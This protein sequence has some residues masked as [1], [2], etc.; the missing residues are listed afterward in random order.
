M[1]GEATPSQLAA[2]LMGLRMR[3]ETV[4]ELAGFA[5][6]MR[7][8]VVRVE[9]PDGHHRR[10]RDR[11]RRQRHVQHLDRGGAGRGGRRAC[12]WP[13][14]ATG[15]SPRRSGSADVLDALGI[16]IDHDAASA[17]R[18]AARDRLRVPVRAELPPGHAPRGPD[19]PGDRRAHRVQ[20][21]RA[22]HEPGRHAPPA[23]RRGRRP[24]A[25]AGSPRS[26]TA[27]GTERTFVVHGDGVDELPLDGS[28]V[29]Y[30]VTDAG[31]ERAS[32]WTRRPSGCRATT[33]SNSPAAT[34]AENARLRRG[35]PARRAR[36]ATRRRPAQRRRCAR[37][38]RRRRGASR[39]AST[40]PP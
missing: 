36:G 30:D 27:S 10:R 4:D 23:A 35:R 29:L 37:R 26:C 20:P 21:A 38:G 33:T 3:G 6:A 39:T 14:T 9:A 19:A 40:G 7:E 13:S 17:G 2:L 16:R 5:T 32:T 22:A 25:P 11:R 1:D 18:G 34:P 12:R 15:R 28:G 24:C 31:I 8:R